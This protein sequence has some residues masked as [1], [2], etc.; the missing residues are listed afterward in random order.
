M[1]YFSFFFNS[2]YSTFWSRYYKE[3]VIYILD[4]FFRG[5][6]V[7]KSEL[8]CNKYI[9]LYFICSIIYYNFIINSFLL[10]VVTD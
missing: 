9:F 1:I 2:F 6:L 8:Y 4:T 5:K 3:A 7:A 10:T